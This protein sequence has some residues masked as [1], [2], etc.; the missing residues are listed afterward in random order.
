MHRGIGRVF[1]LTIRVRHAIPADLPGIT[2]IAGQAVTAAQWSQRQYEQIFSQGRLVLVI[3]EHDHVAGFLVACGM[4]GD[5]EIEN[6]AV[7]DRARRRGLGSRLLNEFLHHVRSSGGMQVALEVR[8][9]NHAARALYKKWAFL[10]A[11]RRKGYYR[12]PHEDALIFKLYFP[13]AP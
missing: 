4:A 8:E 1:I 13:Q 5:W 11:G 2:E 12:D 3:E 6:I 9:S 7:A 10:E